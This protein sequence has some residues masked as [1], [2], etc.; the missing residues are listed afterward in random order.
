MNHYDTEK[1][2]RRKREGRR[3]GGGGGG[4]GMGVRRERRRMR[5][6]EEEEK[7]GKR[8]VNEKKNERKAKRNKV[9][10]AILQ[11][12]NSSRMKQL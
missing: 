2:V 4:V 9:F 10:F 1:L 5:T 8:G 3:E 12:I 11:N 7:E 6:K